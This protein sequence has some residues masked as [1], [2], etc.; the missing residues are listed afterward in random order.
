[1]TTADTASWLDDLNPQQKEAVTYRAAPLL[2]LAGPGSGKTRI[3]T[4]R[5]AWLVRGQ[6]VRPESI[7]A[8]TFTNRAAEEMRERLAVSLGEVAA[9]V[10][11]YTF[12]ATAVRILR[13]F[14]QRVGIDP[15]FIIIDEEDQRQAF[16]RV[17]RQLGLSREVYPPHRLAAYIGQRKTTLSAAPAETEPDPGLIAIADAYEAWLRQRRGLDFDDLIRAAVGLLRQDAETLRHFH[18]TLHHVLVDEYQDIDPVQY[19]LLK[20]LSPPGASITIVADDDQA[21]YGWRGSR[22]ELIDDFI[23]RYQPHIVKLE[24]SYRCPPHILHGAQA[25][26]AHQRSQER[27][28]LMHSAGESETPIYHY[29]FQNIHQEQQW[30]RILVGKLIDERGYRP[31]E[32]AILYRTH[33]L[34]PAIEQT[35]LQAGYQVHR[36]RKDS[37]FDEPQSR[38]VVRYLLLARALQEEYF[39]AA[40]NFPL[41]L[42]DELTMIQLQRLAETRG[43][44]LI[45]VARRADRYSE[46]SPL[47]RSH[48]RR[49]LAL[50]DAHLPAPQTD[51]LAGLRDLFALLQ[52]MR[53][54]W[55][56]EARDLLLNLLARIDDAEPVAAL[57]AALADGQTLA[58]GQPLLILHPATLDGYAAA[59]LM[60]TTLQA[61]LDVPAVARAAEAVTAADLAATACLILLGDVAGAGSIPAEHTRI[62]LAAAPPATLTIQVWRCLQA[63]LVGYET[64]AAGRFVVYDVETTGINVQRDEIVE[65]AAAL[66]ENRQ[67]VGEPFHSLVKPERGYIPRAAIAVHGIHTE[68]VADA[69]SLIQALPDFLEFVGAETVVGH[70]IGRFDNR[71]IDQACGRLQEGRGFNPLYIDTLRLARR[72]LPDLRRHGLDALL[73][74]LE[75]DQDV[76]HRAGRDVA[77]TAELFFTL[78]DFIL[79]EREAEALAEALPL[80][81]LTT[82]AATAELAGEDLLLAQT[83]ARALAANRGQAALADFQAAAPAELQDQAAAAAARLAALPLPLTPED[84][85]WAALQ[86]DFYKHAEIF[87]QYSS[88]ASVA[89][90]LD[91]QALLSSVDTFSYLQDKEHISMMTLHNAKGAEFPVV[92]II[93]LEHDNLPLWRAV[94]DPDMLAEERRVFYV[95]LTRASEALY[96]FSTRNRRDGYLRSPSPFAFEIPAEHVRRFQI[97][98]RGQ[99]RALS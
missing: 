94:S 26:I 36:L 80:V 54:P 13:R 82:L 33:R 51:I 32:I 71:F 17:V 81:G 7:L 64:L 91:Y 5:I 69:P 28:R 97:D 39:Q 29:I 86:E 70:N 40:I 11:V 12:H 60:R 27:Q 46:I 61:Y 78:T 77:A 74:T 14:G 87:Q 96:L 95:G 59:H 56:G 55:R 10:W 41:R 85:A 53:S 93:G 72:L 52:E 42:V 44:S 50:L 22:P 92:I 65:L 75:I 25:L 57:A 2:V 89:A 18:R 6:D 43:I 47:T 45:E 24:T 73:Q 1:M 49:F 98:S 83:A 16:T 67:P 76:T 38:E 99:I 34:A 30:L 37:F 84:E 21:I 62:H 48:L 3:L 88:D 19:E 58:A 9:R 90:F 20:L 35:L 31:G 4:N 79:E 68:D 15:G 23:T 66:Y 63:L 8:V